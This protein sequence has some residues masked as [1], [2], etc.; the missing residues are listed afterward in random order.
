MLKPAESINSNFIPWILTDFCTKSRVV[1]GISETIDV[2]F[3]GNI[4][5]K[6]DFPAFSGPVIMVFTP[7]F[8]STA[9]PILLLNSAKLSLKSLIFVLSFDKSIFVS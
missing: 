6:V 4:F 3:L 8:T 7:S 2:L 5:I 9:S 1:P